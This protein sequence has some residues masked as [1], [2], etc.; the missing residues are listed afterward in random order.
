M[1]VVITAGALAAFMIFS[2]SGAVP[3]RADDI[4]DYRWDPYR[5]NCRDIEIHTT[6]RWGNDVVTRRRVCD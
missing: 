6:N 2:L 5:S 1:K 3:V 4:N